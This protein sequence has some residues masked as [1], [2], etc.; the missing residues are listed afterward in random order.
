MILNNAG[1]RLCTVWLLI[2]TNYK[3]HLRNKI[4]LNTAPIY[5]MSRKNS[6]YCQKFMH[7]ST[8]SAISTVEN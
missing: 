4:T 7:V 3:V 8:M 1:E 2:Q 6:L 5:K